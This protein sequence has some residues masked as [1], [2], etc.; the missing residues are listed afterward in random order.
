M[1][2]FF[3]SK[4]LRSDIMGGITAAIVS[5]PL[6]LTFGVA[7]GVGP[8]AGLYGAIIIG[9][10]AAVFGGTPTLISEPT[11]PMTVVMAA[12]VTSMIADNPDNGLA[13]AFTVVMMAGL[14]QI[15][16][17]MFKL[18][19]Y[20]TQ[21][22]YSVVS[23][24]MSGIGVILIIIQLAPALGQAAP[25]GGV[26]GTI[27]AIPDIITNAQ[28]NEVILTLVTL[29]IL[30]F[31]PKRFTK[32]IPAQLIA[33]VGVSVLSLVAFG[34]DTIRRIGEISVSLPSPVLPSFSAEQLNA[35]L[36]DAVVLGML[37]CIDSM[38]TSVIADNLTRTEHKSD[39]ELI[40]QG[41]GN[42]FSGLLGG[43]PGAGATMG[44][45]VNIQTGARS[46]WSGVTR[47]VTLIIGI[48][49]AAS[50]L[51]SIPLAVLAGIAVK[52][53]I[54]ILDWSF[55][56]RAH[57][58]S[59]QSTLVMYSVL[60]LTV[61]VDLI[62]AVGIGVFVANILII[63]KLSASQSKNVR[64]ISDL[65][66]ELPLNKRQRELLNEA[67]G[68]ILY[69]Y[70]SGPMIFGVSKALAK[71]R[72]NIANH[73]AVIIDLSDVSL[74]DDTMSLSIENMI[75]ESRDMHKEVIVV[76]KTEAGKQQLLKLLQEHEQN[77]EEIVVDSRTQAL[78]LG[79]SKL[80]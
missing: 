43:L 55:I 71:E 6:A 48:F 10:F 11:G 24:F 13:M 31:I 78:E 9:L 69:F 34:P 80:V 20:V 32:R 18:G 79:L 70:L 21:M 5:L 59:W 41:I 65:D 54:D 39:K 73:D 7:S 40:G 37:G 30:F 42:F 57:R 74:L 28:F 14:F 15:A 23:G 8:E 36:A 3:S 35:M 53:G 49:G 67:N 64:A 2:N 66:D 26:I 12:I 38:L 47:V 1:F 75:L 16:F 22:P 27:K 77:L 60:F 29:C 56:K 51:S 33:L 63:E 46:A 45:V 76:V 44:T 25:S 50:L 58:V 4:Y 62:F 52:V 68:R 19:K 17:G 61:F 72:A